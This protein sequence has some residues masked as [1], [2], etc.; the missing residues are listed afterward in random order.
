M[1]VSVTG[2]ENFRRLSS[3]KKMDKKDLETIRERYVLFLNGYSDKTKHEYLYWFSRF[4]HQ[5]FLDSEKEEE[6]QEVINK[7]YL[8]KK[9]DNNVN[10]GFLRSYLKCIGLFKQ[11]DIPERKRGTKKFEIK[12]ALSKE[13]IDK[14][15]KAMYETGYLKGLAFRIIYEGGLRRS[16]LKSVKYNSFLWDG[17]LKKLWTEEPEKNIILKVIG[18]GNKERYVLIST[19]TM[20]NHFNHL[21]AKQNLP[22]TEIINLL[23]NAR[24]VNARIVPFGENWFYKHLSRVSKQ[25]LGRNV[26]PHLLRHSKATH[27]LDDG[28]EVKDIQNYLGHANLFTTET[29]LHR[30]TKQSIRNIMNLGT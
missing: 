7:H 16:E 12:N 22:D 9:N 10:R 19:E 5:E 30:D 13:D 28:G 6:A 23:N 26:N 21:Q 17:W 8:Y 24:N 25:I 2:T 18:K 27:I 29:Y 3:Y 14:L 20:I 15:G 11:F 4:P 1:C